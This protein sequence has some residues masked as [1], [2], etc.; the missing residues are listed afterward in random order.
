MFNIAYY[1]LMSLIPSF[2]VALR[3]GSHSSYSQDVLRGVS[4][5]AS[6]HKNWKF[7]GDPLLSTD[8]EEDGISE[9]ECDGMLVYETRW[10]MLERYQR[11]SI[12]VVNTSGRKHPFEIPTVYSNRAATGK[13]AVEYLWNLGIRRFVLIRKHEVQTSIS[14]ELV[15]T[16]SQYIGAK[17]GDVILKIF[18]DMTKKLDN[19]TSRDLASIIL[20]SSHT[21]GIICETDFLAVHCIHLLRAAGVPLPEKA[22]VLGCGNDDLICQ[23]SSPTLSSVNTNRRRIGYLAAEKLTRWMQGHAPEKSAMGV[24][25]TG[26]VSRESTDILCIEDPKIEHAL[27]FIRA[28]ACEGIQVQDILNHVQVSRSKM[29]KGIRAAIGKSPQEEIRRIQMDHMKTLL[30]TTDLKIR[31]IARQTGFRDSRY[32]SQ[33]FQ[34][35]MKMTPTEYRSHQTDNPD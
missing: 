25:P 33:V 18:S 15:T 10:K 23:F 31:E 29:E 28:H 22:A 6:R 1:I 30:T 21:V 8:L 9:A 11:A 26:V 16:A 4:E 34:K 17:H 35:E 14:P 27:R 5:F 13:L 24:D 19:Q 20:S 12:P 2:R 32:L 3:I 7:I